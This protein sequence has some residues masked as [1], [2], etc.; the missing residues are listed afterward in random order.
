MGAMGFL[1]GT[2]S[3]TG[4]GRPVNPQVLARLLILLLIQALFVVGSCGR[5]EPSGSAVRESS[6]RQKTVGVSLLTMQHQFYQ[7]LRSGLESVGKE[8]GLRLLI[9]SAEFDSTRQAN[10]LDEFIVQK[11]DAIV[12]C[13]CDSRSVGASITAA[14]QAN[15]PVFTADIAN[16]SPI[17]KVI[18]HIASNNVLGGREAAKLLASAMKGK[19]KSPSYRIRKWQA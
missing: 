1:N 14:N 19:E 3:T 18:S 9:V 5:D 11:V 10:Q 4:V 13:P 12:V 15:I 2:P 6:G 16:T 17:G 7:E 8:R